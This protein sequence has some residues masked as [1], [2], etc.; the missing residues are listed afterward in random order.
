MPRHA[1]VRLEDMPR[2][3]HVDNEPF[4]MDRNDLRTKV[5]DAFRQVRL[6]WRHA[7]HWNG[8]HSARIR[9]QD[10]ADVCWE[11]GGTAPAA[12]CAYLVA[13]DP[14]TT[15]PVNMNCVPVARLSWMNFVV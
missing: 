9:L 5:V 12:S 1:G 11:D 3:I 10:L 7:T 2:L 6:Q 4:R 14:Y 13:H 15:I 8:E